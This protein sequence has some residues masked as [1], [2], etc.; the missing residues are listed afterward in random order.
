M[1]I[2]PGKTLDGSYIHKVHCYTQERESQ[3]HILYFVRKETVMNKEVAETMIH[4]DTV[5]WHII[6]QLRCLL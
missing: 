3:I 4:Y 1:N 6:H 2:W 5:G